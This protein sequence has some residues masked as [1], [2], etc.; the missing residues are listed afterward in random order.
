V[1]A[2][3]QARQEKL[4]D[5]EAGIIS[6]YVE[7]NNISVE[8][9]EDGIYYLP[10]KRGSGKMPQKQ[11]WA[12]VHYTV[13]TLDGNKLFASRERAEEPLEFEVGNRFENEGFQSVVKMM[14]EGGTCE[15]LIPSAMAFG[16][17]GAGDV[18]APYTPLYYEI[19][20]IDVMTMDEYDRKQKDAQAKKEAVKFAKMEQEKEI[21]K[22]WI[23]EKGYTVTT[24]LEGGILYIETSKG[25]GRKPLK[26]ERVKVHYTGKLLDGSVFDSSVEKGA[27][28]LEFPLGRGAVIRGWDL[29]IAEMNKGSQG[30]LV[31]PFDKG[32]GER[33]SGDRIPPYSTLVFEV[34]LVD[35]VEAPAGQ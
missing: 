1:Q 18:V 4:K 15:A 21:I 29:G 17:Q 25:D 8:P 31:I 14:K 28:P 16:A 33:G 12:S 5:A 2:E 11:E 19:E 34:E 20:L 13:Y 27:P 23:A 6:Q 35:I 7:E 3:E 22:D 32:Y 26:G 24:E 30:I 10:K 9:N